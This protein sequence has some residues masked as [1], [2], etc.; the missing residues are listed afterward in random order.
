MTS[1]KFPPIQSYFYKSRN[2]VLLFELILIA[3]KSLS[4]L[5][6]VRGKI[7]V[8]RYKQKQSADLSL[9]FQIISV[10][11]IRNYKIHNG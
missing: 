3:A 1:A 6:F 8:V 2:N 9:Y 5:S 7:A 10:K 4:I 11:L